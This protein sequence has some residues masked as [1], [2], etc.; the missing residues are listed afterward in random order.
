[1]E[2][3]DEPKAL[4]IC[5][6]LIEQKA[7]VNARATKVHPGITALHCAAAQGYPEV[8][9]LLLAHKADASLT[10]ENGQTPLMMAQEE[11]IAAVIEVFH[12]AGVTR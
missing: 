8:V 5:K 10:D 9:K 6:Y 2:Y 1:M 7:N 3:V 4:A 11:Q 12:Q